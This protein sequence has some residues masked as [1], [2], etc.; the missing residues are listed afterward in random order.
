MKILYI[1]S[2]DFSYRCLEKIISLKYD[3]R[4]I[5]TKRKSRFNSDF[6]DL[7]NIPVSNKVMFRYVADINSE[8][9]ISWIKKIKP[10]LILCFG[11][12][13][14]LCDKILEIPTIGTIGYHPSKLPKNRGRHPII[15]AIVLGLKKTA[16]TFFFMDNSADTGD[17]LNQKIVRIDK[18]DNAKTLYD[19]LV[20]IGCKQIEEFMPQ[21][22]NGSY[23]KTKQHDIP[24]N[25]WRKRNLND[26]V[27]DWRMSGENI[28]NLVRALSEPYPGASFFYNGKEI[29]IW[30]VIVHKKKY[31]NLEPGKIVSFKNGNPVVKAGLWCVELVRFDSNINFKIGDYL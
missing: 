5:I 19:R 8:N 20:K 3:V 27:I 25:N 11:W 7:S 21:L 31:K 16:S 17:I 9:N 30:E 1:G 2:V 13:Q 26:G 18:K 15:W 10:D 6:K 24:G 23:V 4:A 14:L 28:Y 29:K 22:K 12:S